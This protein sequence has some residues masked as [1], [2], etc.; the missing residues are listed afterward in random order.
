MKN[1]PTFGPVLEDTK[2][3]LAKIESEWKDDEILSTAIM[4]DLTGLPLDEHFDVYITHPCSEVDVAQ[5]GRRII[6]TYREKPNK[7]NV[8]NL[9]YYI[10]SSLLY[11]GRHGDKDHRS[12]KGWAIRNILDLL[13]LE[14]RKRMM[15]SAEMPELKGSQ[16]LLAESWHMYLQQKGHK[17]IN[18][19]IAQ[20]CQVLD[21]AKTV[22]EPERSK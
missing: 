9:W 2:A 6:C 16:L 12:T 21:S 11:E 5:A 8:V 17:D 19:Y 7:Y 10:C 1:D 18:Q 20:A 15:G 3:A 22:K 4:Q 13:F 14:Q